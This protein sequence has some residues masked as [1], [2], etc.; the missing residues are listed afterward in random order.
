MKNSADVEKTPIDVEKT[1]IYVEKG[2]KDN[3][4]TWWFSSEL[5]A[6]GFSKKITKLKKGIFCL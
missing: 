3:I 2:H 1:P 5:T 4:K 6:K